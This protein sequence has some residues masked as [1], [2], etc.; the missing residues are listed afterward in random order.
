MP[1]RRERVFIGTCR[2][3]VGQGRPATKRGDDIVVDQALLGARTGVVPTFIMN[4][5]GQFIYRT[6]GG[7][8]LS[9]LCGVARIEVTLKE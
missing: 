9:E 4:R 6:V 1:I 3:C 7:T 8:T 2:P 5:R